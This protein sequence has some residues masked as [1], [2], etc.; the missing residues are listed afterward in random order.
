MAQFIKSFLL[1]MSGKSFRKKLKTILGG[2]CKKSKK[3]KNYTV[4]Y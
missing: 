2:V 4:F 3:V 1:K